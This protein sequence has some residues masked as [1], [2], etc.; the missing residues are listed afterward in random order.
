MNKRT[1][2][3]KTRQTSLQLFSA[4]GPSMA[5]WKRNHPNADIRARMRVRVRTIFK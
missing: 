1:R 4:P 2:Q 5:T 3:N